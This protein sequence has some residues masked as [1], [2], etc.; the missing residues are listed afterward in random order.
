MTL[1]EHT[2]R[3]S[4]PRLIKALNKT[5]AF[6]LPAI[7]LNSEKAGIKLLEYFG[8]VNC[9]I[10]HKQAIIKGE[11]YVYVVFNPSTEAMKN[12]YKFYSVYRDYA[13][14]V[15]DYMLDHNLIVLVFKVK[16]KWKLTYSMYKESRYSLMSK[17]YA[18]MFKKVS[19]SGKVEIGYQYLIIHK[20][21]EYREY[22]EKELDV[23]IQANAEL[24]DVLDESK[25]IFDYDKVV[26]I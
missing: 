23:K 18:D 8:F 24:M 25:E 6:M 22:L 21:K 16:D 1:N 13:T 9:Y 3:I 7:D 14:F 4:K 5:S 12:F 19:M 20:H 26:K 10:E 2:K 15:N 11:N 17:E